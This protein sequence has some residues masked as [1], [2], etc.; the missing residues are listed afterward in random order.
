MPLLTWIHLSD[1]HA[2]SP[3]YGWDSGEVLRSLTDD[4]DRLSKQYDLRPDLLFFTGD[5]AFGTRDGISM[6]QQFEE[7]WRILSSVRRRFRARLPPNRCFV[8]PGNHDL[9]RTEI[10]RENQDWLDRLGNADE[11]AHILA[12]TSG[13]SFKTQQQTL[14]RFKPYRSF[15]LKAGLKHCGYDNPTLLYGKL[16]RINGLSVGIAGFNS[17]I[18]CHKDAENGKLWMAARWQANQLLPKLDNADIKI[19]LV[20]HPDNWLHPQEKPSRDL[21][22]QVDFVLLGPEHDQWINPA[23]PATKGRI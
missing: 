12:A 16:L 2:N 14:A 23:R 10:L 1:L 18:M 9:D 20:H 7:A 21:S 13:S 22:T 15:L 8:V 19:A 17:A 11:L 5:A 6:S 4:L 3:H